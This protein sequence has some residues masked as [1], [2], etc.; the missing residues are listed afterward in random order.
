[1]Y[2]INKNDMNKYEVWNTLIEKE[3]GRGWHLFSLTGTQLLPASVSL[4]TAKVKQRQGYWRE[5]AKGR[6]GAS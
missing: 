1:M 3:Q 2:Y 4:L 6:G 5:G